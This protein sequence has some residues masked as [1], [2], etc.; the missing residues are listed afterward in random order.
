LLVWSYCHGLL[1]SRRSS[2]TREVYYYYVTHF[3]SQTECDHV[4]L[5]AARL[6][7]VSRTD[8]GL[9]TSPRGWFI[10][11]VQLLPNPLYCAPE[12]TVMNN[13]NRPM[14]NSVHH[15]DQRFSFNDGDAQTTSSFAAVLDGRMTQSSHG[16]P[17]SSD[18]LYPIQHRPYCLHT[19]AATCVLVVEKEGVY[20]RLAEDKFFHRYPCIIVTGKGFP[21]VATRAFVHALHTNL[22]IPV[23]GLAD[24][25]PFGVS[26]LNT[27]Q[28]SSNRCGLEGGGRFGVPMEWLG[29][30]PLQVAALSCTNVEEFRDKNRDA[31][32]DQKP[33]E[34]FSGAS[35]QRSLP[36]E[37][38]QRMTEIDCRRLNSLLAVDSPNYWTG[39]GRN[40]KRMTE[41][42]YMQ[43]TGY[44]VELEALNWLG[45]DFCALWL[46]QIFE[47]NDNN[48]SNHQIKVDH[49]WWDII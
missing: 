34:A 3:R 25:N 33:D 11:D 2:T 45:M 13:A 24:C 15:Q 38:F 22:G 39:N 4:I 48:L 6:L 14:T 8:L 12:S 20:Q 46:S 41:L 36:N 37:V 21:D 26:V 1:L 31:Q 7:D 19:I 40:V 44:K 18:W 17:I 47:N 30:R 28:Q 5:E 35:K 42:E 32:F 10:G 23:R 43:Q 16:F 9:R 49:D 29:L 27:Y